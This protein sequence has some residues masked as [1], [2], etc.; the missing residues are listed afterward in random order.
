MELKFINDKM[1]VPKARN[2]SYRHA[3]PF[4]RSI[5]SRSPGKLSCQLF[6][7]AGGCSK[8]EALSTALLLRLLWLRLS[9]LDEL[10]SRGVVVSG[11]SR[12]DSEV[13]VTN[14]IHFVN[15]SV[16]VNQKFAT[17]LE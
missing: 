6:Q 14:N 9:S 8:E 12:I 11:V 17:W 5:K 13:I 16:N 7:H 2:Q 10:A 1:V 4:L 3:F 15:A